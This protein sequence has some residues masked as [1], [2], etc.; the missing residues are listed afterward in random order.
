MRRS[1]RMSTI[2]GLSK[3]QKDAAA[4]QFAQSQQLLEQSETQLTDMQRCRQ[5]YSDQL[6]TGPSHIRT[7]SELKG[8]R[9]FIQQL[10][11]AIQQL[12]L[13]ILERKATNER[14][15]DQW[16]Q[17]HN[18]TRALSNVKERYASDEQKTMDQK[19]QFEIDELSQRK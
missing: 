4:K 9:I 16:L 12:E 6:G 17:L 8:I 7:A 18:K 2:V 10:D 1:N 15:Q 13:Q 14:H 11:V 3:N 19:E 5:E